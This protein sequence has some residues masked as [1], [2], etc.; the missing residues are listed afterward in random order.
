M[1]GQTLFWVQY[2]ADTYSVMTVEWQQINVISFM[3]NCK[4]GLQFFHVSH[5][6]EII[7]ICCHSAVIPLYV[8]AV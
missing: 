8:F 1:R 2:I 3:E 5:I 6:R 4:H 7:L